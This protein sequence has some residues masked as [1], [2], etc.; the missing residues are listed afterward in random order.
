M[1]VG[2][3][4]NAVVASRI[5]FVVAALYDGL[6]GLAFLVA[7]GAIFARFAVTPPNHVGYVQF[8]GALLIVFALMFA[9]IARSPKRNRGL[10]VYGILLKVSYSGVVFG[11]WLARGVPNMWKPFALADVLFIILF[12]LAYVGLAE[13]PAAALADDQKA[14]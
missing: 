2:A 8:P 13:R 1:G 10:I 5:L 4:M 3:V 14:S 9:A 11:H 6:L 7:S 12:V